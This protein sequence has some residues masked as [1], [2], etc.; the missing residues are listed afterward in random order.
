VVESSR[1][2]LWIGADVMVDWR[3]YTDLYRELLAQSGYLSANLLAS[4]PVSGEL[5]PDWYEDWVLM[6]RERF[7]QLRLHALESLC[8]QFSAAGMPWLAVE[9]GLGAVAAEPLR[10]SAHRALIQA[11]LAI[12]NRSEAMR[13]FNVYR[14]LIR[15]ELGLEPTALMAELLSR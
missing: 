5:L 2:H 11:H 1:T 9:A 12:G 8:H 10:E 4:V 3:V 7:R 15:E 14:H 13:Q 6:E